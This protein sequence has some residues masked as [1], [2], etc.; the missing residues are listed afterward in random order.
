MDL[1]AGH[2]VGPEDVVPLRPL[3][4]AVPAGDRDSVI[5]R[6]L[7]HPVGAGA[8][9]PPRRPR[10]GTPVSVRLLPL[11]EADPIPDVDPH[12]GPTA[13]AAEA[14][15]RGARAVVAEV[16][17]PGLA[18]ACPLVL[19]PAGPHRFLARSA[20]YGGPFL[21]AGTPV[22]ARFAAVRRALDAALAD[23]GVISEVWMLAPGLEGR[24]EIALGL[25][26]GRRQ[27]DPDRRPG[28]RDAG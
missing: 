17:V 8:A 14:A 15:E 1:A 21:R 13:L 19:E 11:A 26:D 27:G 12:S 22:V 3:G 7:V 18:V 24:D 6:R 23:A 4:D 25:A 9:P 20:E 28:G 10:G 5:G 16:A 2:T